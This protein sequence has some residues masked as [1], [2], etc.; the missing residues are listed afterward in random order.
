MGF[1]NAYYFIMNTWTSVSRCSLAIHTIHL[2]ANIH[3]DPIGIDPTMEYQG[4][5]C[6]SHQVLKDET[7]RS[8]D[9][10]GVTTLLTR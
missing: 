4:F 5:A 2:L 9:S 7:L 1:V 6:F 10:I 3:T 8:A